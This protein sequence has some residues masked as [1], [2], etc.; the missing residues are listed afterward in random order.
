MK[1]ALAIWHRFPIVLR[2]ILSGLLVLF[3]GA[4]VWT[5]MVVVNLKLTNSVP[6]AAPTLALFLWVYWRY[7]DGAGW[8]RSTAEVR[9]R[10]FR[11]RALA[12]RVWIWALG[13]GAIALISAVAL[14][15]LLE[16]LIRVPPLPLQDLSRYPS[17]TVVCLLVAGAAEAGIV[18]EAAF[19]GYM[20]APIERRYGPVVAIAVV[21]LLFGF[22]HLVNGAQELLWLPVYS[23]VGVIL[24]ALAYLTNSVL[25][26]MVLHSALDIFRFFASSRRGAAAQERLIWQSGSNASFWTSLGIGV[27]LGALAIWT[28]KR[29]ALVARPE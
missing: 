21:E 9:H 28:Y 24:G 26:G 5:A 22:V 20:Q 19:R 10:N 14:Q 18:E 15:S 29:L 17:F 11:A 2:A 27:I 23:L 8:P 13:A 1:F 7:L 3:F 4:L 6:W 16:R 12:G 25:P